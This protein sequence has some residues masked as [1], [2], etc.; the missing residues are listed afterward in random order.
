MAGYIISCEEVLTYFL[1]P[2]F[3]KIIG[4]PTRKALTKLHH[5]II[6]NMASIVSNLGGVCHDH[7][8]LTMNVD[9]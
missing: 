6:S 3:L 9:D 7:L 5:L 1:T 2:I 8:A 4:E